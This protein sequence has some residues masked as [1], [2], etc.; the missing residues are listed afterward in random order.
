MQNKFVQ[1]ERLCRFVDL[2]RVYRGWSRTELSKVLGRDPSKI[3]PDSGNPKL[4]LIV[5]LADALDWSVGDVA[6]S[7]WEDDATGDVPECE[8]SFEAISGASIEAR[9]EGRFDD[10]LRLATRLRLVAET[11]REH[12]IACLREGSV[13]DRRGRYARALECAQEGLGMNCRDLDV[14]TTLQ[15]RL[16]N[17]HYTLWHLVEAKAVGR[18]LVEAFGNGTPD[19]PVL[20]ENLGMAHYAIGQSARRQIDPSEPE[21]ARRLEESR[22]HLRTASSIF[23][24]LHRDRARPTDLAFARICAGGLLEVDAAAGRLDPNDAIEQVLI[25]L[26]GAIDVDNCPSVD[27][28]ESHGWWAIFGCNIALRHLDGS[29][30]HRPMAIFTNKA[31]EIAERIGNW[32]L[33][34]RAFTL[35]HFRRQRIADLV[36]DEQDWFLD[37]EEI[38]TITGTMGRFPGFRRIGWRI[39]EA[40]RVFDNVG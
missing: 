7:V 25:E 30:I 38:R 5:G 13:W 14:R 12:A 39:L 10:A 6:E 37:E 18:D 34:E 9:H 8:H 16:A 20:R 11:D 33:R 36:G 28:L 21:L 26:E 1:R 22:T 4:D 19:D 3:V 15:G 2:A 29:E 31:L 27:L 24:D 17:A 40:A 35:E 32:G 23:L